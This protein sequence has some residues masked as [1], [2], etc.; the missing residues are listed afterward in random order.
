VDD[1]AEPALSPSAPPAPWATALQAVVWWHRATDAAVDALPERLRGRPRLPVTVAA[2]IR[3]AETPVGPYHEVLATPVILLEAPL[4]A[5]TVP[6]IAVDSLA[7]IAGGRSNWALPKTRARFE[8]S[9][10]GRE[11]A[12]QGDGWGVAARVRPRGPA[13]PFA[14]PLRNRQVAPDGAELVTVLR[15]RGR[16]RLGRAAVEV[17]GP[18]RPP[19]LRAGRHPAVVVP[20][21]RLHVDAPRRAGR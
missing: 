11:L 17:S 8:W 21:A 12:A 18:S 20:G 1:L 6:F 4:P 16:L 3:Y 13:L 9:G 14:A 15:A 2:L 5:T 10:A 7:S 19:W